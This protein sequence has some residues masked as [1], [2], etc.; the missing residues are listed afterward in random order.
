MFVE[1]DQAGIIKG[2]YRQPQPGYA[3][4]ELPETHPEVVDFL[5]RANAPLPRAREALDMLIDYVASKPDAPPEI[6]SES[7]RR[8]R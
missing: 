2:L 4:E 7:A 1:R 6:V 5:T 8:R 3:E